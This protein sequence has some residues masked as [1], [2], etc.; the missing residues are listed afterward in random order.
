M[1]TST[2]D[3][4]RTSR[5]D[6]LAVL[7]L[8]DESGARLWIDGGWGVD[9][10][11]GTQTREHGDLD[12]AIESRHLPA[13]LAALEAAGFHKAGETGATAWNFLVARP[14]GP[15]VD[16]HV[17]V[18]DADGNG[19]L[20]PPEHGSAYPAGSL[21]GRGT[22]GDRPVDCIAPAFVVRFHDAYTGDAVDRADVHAI[23]TRYDLPIPGQYR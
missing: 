14:G 17:V 13:F 16:L 12:V 6:V 22:I 3:G 9:A 20:G 8:A 2:P 15:V 1:A 5:D 11:L 7:R 19:V 21:T 4:A 23:C 18:L 10:L